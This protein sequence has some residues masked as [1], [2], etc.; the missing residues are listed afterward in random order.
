MSRDRINRYELNHEKS[1]EE[2][3]SQLETYPDAF[4][5]WS[6]MHQLLS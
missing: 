2:Y 3:K 4:E 6:K 5:Y 1:E